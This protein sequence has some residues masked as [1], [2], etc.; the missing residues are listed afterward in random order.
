MVS[1]IIQLFFVMTSL[2][3]ILYRKKREKSIIFPSILTFFHFLILGLMTFIFIT[4]ALPQ[5]EEGDLENIGSGLNKI[6]RNF[7]SDNAQDKNSSETHSNSLK[8]N[9]SEKDTEGLIDEE[10]KRY[11]PPLENPDGNM[12]KKSDIKDPF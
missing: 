3:V 10:E 7:F 8:N 11:L 1:I 12:N 5:R 9:F 2:L 6:I 4:I